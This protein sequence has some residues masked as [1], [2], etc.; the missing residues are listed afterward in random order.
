M[1][2][3]FGYGCFSCTPLFL[4]GVLRRVPS[5]ATL[6][7]SRHPLVQLPVAWVVWG[8]PWAGLLPPPLFFA[9]FLAAGVQ[10]L[11]VSF[12]ALSC[13]GSVVVAVLGPLVSA[14][15][16]SFRLGFF[17]LFFCYVRALVAGGPPLLRSG[18]RWRVRGVFSSGP[19]V[20]VWLWWDTAFG[21]AS[22]GWA[23]WSPGVLSVG[24]VGVTFGLALLGGCPPLVEL[25]RGFPVVRLSPPLCSF[26]VGRMVC[27]HGM[28]GLP[29][30][31][32]FFWGG[33]FLFLP[34]PSLGRCTHWSAFGVANRVAVGVVGGRPRPRPHGSGVV[35]TRLGWWPVLSG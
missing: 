34:L 33:G 27:V 22:S 23:V 26:P 7:V 28:V 21:W 16:S 25:V 14:P 18:V 13:C 9:V 24:P 8:S 10:G 11:W 1:V 4:A 30:F 17:C 15:P 31:F 29:P 20:A 19:S 3:V 32:V 35:C 2:H 5:C 12:S 6:F